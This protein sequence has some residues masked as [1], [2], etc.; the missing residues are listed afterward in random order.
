MAKHPIYGY[1]TARPKV[2]GGVGHDRKVE[3][4]KKVPKGAFGASSTDQPLLIVPKRWAS[5]N[6]YRDLS[7]SGQLSVLL[8]EIS[9][10]A[11]SLGENSDAILQKALEKP[12]KQSQVYCPK[13]TLDLVKSGRL[14]VERSSTK[15]RP[16]TATISYGSNGWP[17]YAAIVHEKTQ[18]RHA[19]PTRAKFLE[20]AVREDMGHIRDTITAGAKVAIGKT[21]I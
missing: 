10:L 19:P 11:R 20:A 2:R 16:A 5:V 6:Y 1:S 13:D 7:F 17:F 4:L 3:N 8:G 9:D 18:N 12:F 15:G 14:T 21:T